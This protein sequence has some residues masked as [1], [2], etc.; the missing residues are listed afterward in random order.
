MKTIKIF[1]LLLLVITVGT[2]GFMSCSKKEVTTT[3]PSKEYD[4]PLSTQEKAWLSEVEQQAQKTIE[5]NPD[6]KT[7]LT[8]ANP[9]NPYDY[10][11]VNYVGVLDEV[12]NY[13]STDVVYVNDSTLNACVTENNIYNRIKVCP[14][15][16]PD[17]PAC[18]VSNFRFGAQTIFHL[19]SDYFSYT[20]SILGVLLSQNRI[21]NVEYAFMV[22]YYDLTHKLSRNAFIVVTKVFENAVANS[23]LLNAAQKLRLLGALATAKYAKD[24][25]TKETN[26]PTSAFRPLFDR[27]TQDPKLFIYEYV[28]MATIGYLVG[29]TQDNQITKGT[30]VAVL[31]SYSDI[32]YVLRPKN[33]FDCALFT[34][35]DNSPPYLICFIPNGKQ[36]RVPSVPCNH[37]S[38]L[39]AIKYLICS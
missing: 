12:K 33:K 24:Y 2:I 4:V 7:N 39:H 15:L 13:I 28:D 23:T 36:C 26:N 1:V 16:A 17:A 32:I 22:I 38:S 25:W 10:V 21:T 19:Y 30:R 11:G 31:Y 14:V 9:N 34:P 29:Q 3:T 5:D 37:T 20:D 35:P 8:I 18:P 6:A 27:F